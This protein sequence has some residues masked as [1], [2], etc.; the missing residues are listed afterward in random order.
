MRQGTIKAFR[1]NQLFAGVAVAAGEADG[2]LAPGYS[3]CRR[4]DRLKS[5]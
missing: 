5:S 2:D 1:H 4:R 3:R